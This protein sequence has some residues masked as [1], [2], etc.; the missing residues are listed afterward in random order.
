M[1]QRETNHCSVYIND[2]SSMDSPVVKYQEMKR[3]GYQFKEKVAAK[4]PSIPVIMIQVWKI[5]KEEKKQVKS[6]FKLG[7]C[8]YVIK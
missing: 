4:I 1:S 6:C 7:L 8:D 5:T 3:L 2:P